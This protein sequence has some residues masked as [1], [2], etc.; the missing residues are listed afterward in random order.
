MSTPVV[1]ILVGGILGLLDGLSA[2]FYPE[3]RVMMI[4]I[5]IGSTVK[6]VLT[7]LAV[8]FVSRWRKSLLRGVLAGVVVGFVLST[9]AAV[10][11]PD[12][13]WAIVLPG[14]LVGAIAA[15]IMP[16]YQPRRSP[17]SRLELLALVIVPL[18]SSSGR[19]IELMQPDAGKSQLSQLDVLIGRWEGTSD[20]QPGKGAVEREYTRLF[21]SRF[22]QV[23][24]RSIYE[25]QEKNPKGETHED[26]GIFS[27]DRTRNRI[28]LR[29]FHTEGFV[30]QYVSDVSAKAATLV[31]TTEAIENIPA[32]YRARET[33]ILTGSDAFEEIFEIAEPSKEYDVY[34][35]SRLRRVR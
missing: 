17:G 25:P 30:N 33:Y 9:V 20:G 13:Y 7:G 21:G 5:V 18:L 31:F 29:Q 23:R 1:G 10:G 12:H 26:L 4:P 15:V 28:V 35:R 19:A 3:A 6:G 27:V 8:G 14:M 11:Q 16:V 34:S 32:G 22:V 2:W 24:N